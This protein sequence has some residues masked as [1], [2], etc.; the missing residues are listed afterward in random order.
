MRKLAIGILASDGKVK[1]NRL[2]DY[3]LMG[4]LSLDGSILP[5]KGALP[6][7][8]KAREEGF[9]GLII[10][11]ANVC[12]AAVV[13]N[14]EVYGVENRLFG[15]AVNVAGLLCGRDLAAGLAGK[16]LGEELLLPQVML[17]HETDKFLDDTT[18]PWLEEQLSVPI[19]VLPI[20]GSALLD[21]LLGP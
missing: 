21:A 6:I 7:A 12:E 8:I 2:G 4:E 1:S 13:N 19:R 11:K 9:K 18:V 20:D 17:R 5:I 15:G 3:M 14:L 16:E 10:P